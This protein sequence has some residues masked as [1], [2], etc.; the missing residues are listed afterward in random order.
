M[1]FDPMGGVVIAL[2][3]TALVVGDFV[4]GTATTNDGNTSEF[5]TNLDIT[6]P[7]D[8]RRGRRIVNTEHPQPARWTSVN[9]LLDSRPIGI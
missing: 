5:G 6:V 8:A 2:P 1:N 9:F 7:P 4:T 3:S